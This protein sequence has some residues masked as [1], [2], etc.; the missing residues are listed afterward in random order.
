MYHVPSIAPSVPVGV[1]AEYF[2]DFSGVVR[3]SATMMEYN[4]VF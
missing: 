1:P 2:Q 4:M 3:R